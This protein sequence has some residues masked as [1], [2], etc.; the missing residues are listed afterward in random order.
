MESNEAASE[1]TLN[2]AGHGMSRLVTP[3]TVIVEGRHG[4]DTVTGWVET[5]SPVYRRLVRLPSNGSRDFTGHVEFVIDPQP[6]D[7]RGPC[8]NECKSPDPPG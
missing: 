8:P 1:I 6:E 7:G 5:I 2:V 4:A 3:I